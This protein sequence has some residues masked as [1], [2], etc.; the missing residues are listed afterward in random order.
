METLLHIFF[1]GG[2]EAKDEKIIF[3][4]SIESEHGLRRISRENY[5]PCPGV[6][7]TMTYFRLT[8]FVQSVSMVQTH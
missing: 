4:S 8:N 7:L 3:S 1:F 2:G 6:T 5:C